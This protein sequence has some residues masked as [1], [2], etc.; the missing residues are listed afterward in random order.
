MSTTAIT[1]DDQLEASL[2]A[3]YAKSFTEKEA[4]KKFAYICDRRK[5]NILEE[6][7]LKRLGTLLRKYDLA[8]FNQIK[9]V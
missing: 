6:Y 2:N 8:A 9:N 1:Q 7:R 3:L 5:V 4:I